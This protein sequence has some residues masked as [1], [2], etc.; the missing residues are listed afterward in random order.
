MRKLS[1]YLL[2]V[3]FISLLSTCFQPT[4]KA[5]AQD[6]GY[7]PPD[8]ICGTGPI[9]VCCGI[10]QHCQNG[11]CVAIPPT[12]N[13]PPQHIQCPPCGLGCCPLGQTGGN[14]DDGG[15]SNGED[16][17]SNSNPD[18]EPTGTA[19]SNSDNSSNPCPNGVSNECVPGQHGISWLCNCSDPCGCFK[20]QF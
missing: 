20:E 15:G 8:R 14:P 6:E 7:C 13:C 1:S 2:I 9:Q 12:T 5:F 16:A 4:Y 17:G 11:I 18:A 3:T 19:G 10:C